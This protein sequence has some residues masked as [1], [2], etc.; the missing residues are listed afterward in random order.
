MTTQPVIDHD[1]LMERLGGDVELAQEILE[2]FDE[3]SGSML[4]AVEQAVSD[5]DAKVLERAA[6][7]LKGAL[8]NIAAGPAAKVAC[9]LEELGHS[10]TVQGADGQVASLREEIDRLRR[11]LQTVSA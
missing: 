2:L 10:G 9:G 11:H 8:L 6:H 7:T 3:E 1:E 4:A 5:A